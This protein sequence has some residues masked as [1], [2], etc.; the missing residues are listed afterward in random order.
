MLSYF[1]F[2]QRDLKEDVREFVFA[3]DDSKKADEARRIIADPKSTKRQVSG[4]IVPSQV[5]YNAEWSYHLDPSTVG[6][7]ELAME[8][9]DANVQWVEEN[10]G[11]IG[12]SALPGLF[13]CPWS[14]RLIREVFPIKPSRSS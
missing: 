12:G 9:C 4:T 11:D 1:V 8:V 2:Q 7:F 14:S 10:L 6:F 3:I 13:W 5:W